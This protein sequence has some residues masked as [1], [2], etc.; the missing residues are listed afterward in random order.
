MSENYYLILAGG[1]GAAKLIEGLAD[2]VSPELLKIIINTGDDIELFGLN[3]CP[4]LDIITYTL[5][6]LVDKEKGWGF[7]NDTF[8]CLSIL[9]KYYETGWFNAGDK[10]L[11]THIYRTNLFKKGFTKY[12]VTQIICKKLGV[13]SHLIPMCNEPVETYIQT[14]NEF[15]H[16]EEFFIKHRSEPEVL[17]VRFKGMDKAT[18]IKEVF[19]FIKETKRIIICPSNPIVSIGTILQVKGVRKALSKVKNK[20]FGISPI[21]EGATVKGPADKLMES[22]GLEVSCVGV[23]DYY[24][25]I[26]G[27][28]IIDNKDFK[29]KPR[30]ENLGIKTYCYDTLM[31]SLNKKRELAQ[32]LVNLEN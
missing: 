27:H 16:F 17:D 1:V 14:P 9:K 25:D 30:V 6:D 22:F 8:N 13:R 31:T 12:Q 18:P 19:K 11:A 20:V 3:I 29:F 26:L 4:D 24:K 7:T 2:I 28:F 23:A 10:D 32:F 5:A 21:I 15:M